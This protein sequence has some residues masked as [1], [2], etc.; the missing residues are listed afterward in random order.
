MSGHPQYLNLG[1]RK[2]AAGWLQ[3]EFGE[4][5]RMLAADPNDARARF[6]LSEATAQLAAVLR[7]SDPSRAEQLYRRSLAL[8]SSVLRSDLQD[9]EALYWQM[10]N[11]VGFAWVLRR[12]AKR[13]QALTELDRAVEGLEAL[14]RRDPADQRFPED[15]GTALR[16]RAAHRLEVG[17]TAGAEPDL[18]RSLGLLEPLYQANPRNLT[19]LRD[20]ADCHQGFGDLVARRSNW[21]QALRSYRKSL[22]LWQG[23]K[24]VGVSSVY[25]RQRQDLAARLVA[26][27]AKNSR[28]LLAWPIALIPLDHSPVALAWT[29]GHVCWPLSSSSCRFRSS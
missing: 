10:I 19:L 27:A 12:L 7:E 29:S 13:S 17:D 23:W 11:R 9:K 21:K 22:E 6:E 18:E 1:D 26:Q 3:R 24:Q 28:R 4:A 14:A 2:A 8:S 20:L 15:L 16:T 25:D 5:E